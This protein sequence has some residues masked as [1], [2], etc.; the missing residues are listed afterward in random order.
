MSVA[1]ASW[2][3]AN[4]YLCQKAQMQASLA[5]WTIKKEN[6]PSVGSGCVIA[7]TLK[8]IVYDVD[9]R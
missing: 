1:A 5:T 6:D 7:F 4:L 2:M 9:G 3:A 8:R